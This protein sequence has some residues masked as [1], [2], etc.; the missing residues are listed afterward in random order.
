MIW[1]A[2]FQKFSL[3]CPPWGHLT[4]IVNYANIKETQSLGK[5]VVDKS[6]WIKTWVGTNRFQRTKVK[7][8]FRSWS[9]LL[10]DVL[11]RFVLGPI[12]FNIYLNDLFS[13]SEMT[14]VCNYADTSFHACNVDLNFLLR[15]MEP[16]TQLGVEWCEC[17]YMKL[18]IR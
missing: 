16:D 3:W 12:L 1:R 14:H 11:Q 6:A 10:R 4:E 15:R 2:K 7:G 8:S 9:E 5:K 17:N 13:L 18:N